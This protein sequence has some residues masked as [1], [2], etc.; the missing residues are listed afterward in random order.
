[1][2]KKIFCQKCKTEINRNEIY[3][4]QIEGKWNMKKLCKKCF[5]KVLNDHWNGN[6]KIKGM[7]K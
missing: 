5:E 1:M 7:K 6:G 4:P 3:V 2:A